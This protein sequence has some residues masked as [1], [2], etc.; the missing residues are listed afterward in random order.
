MGEW[1][2]PQELV[3]DDA[4]EAAP[5]AVIDG[6]PTLGMWGNG[7]LP[8][9][10]WIPYNVRIVRELALFDAKPITTLDIA[11]GG[12]LLMYCLGYYGHR[13]LGIDRENQLFADMADAL[14][15]ERRVSPVKPSR[16]LEPLGM[17][18]LITVVSPAFDYDWGAK[19]WSYF[20]DDV[21]ERLNP[22]GRLYIRLNNDRWPL[23]H[24]AL[25]YGFAPPSKH[26]ND[27]R[28]F[29]MTIQ[30]SAWRLT[31]YR[32][33]YGIDTTLRQCAEPHPM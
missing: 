31:P 19:E 30:A 15:V 13:A 6:T 1:H 5:V 26:A 25:A 4:I 18:D 12:G 16:P 23:L 33:Q 24:E 9:P 32:V 2:R 11:C 14:G 21:S 22:G 28:E 10:R 20:L 29:I 7:S 17:F 3:G 8:D 27:R